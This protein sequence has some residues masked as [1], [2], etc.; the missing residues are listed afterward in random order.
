MGL[1][2]DPAIPLLG[3]FPKKL[4]ALS[5]MHPHTHCSAIYNSQVTETIW[6][7]IN[8]W[9]DRETA[10]CVCV[11]VCIH[12]IVCCFSRSGVSDS[13]W[14]HELWPTR[15][16][17]PWDSPGNNTGVGS[18]SLLQGSSQ[19][20]DQSWV[21]LTAGRFLIPSEPPYSVINK[22]KTL[23]LARARMD[24]KGIVLSEISQTKRDKYCM[25]S[26]T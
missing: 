22:N 24:L 23:P 12:T 16:F 25:I 15:R 11:C 20:R 26:H 1:P 5:R 9:M 8:G 7:S 21:S 4:K 2:C 6:V 18:H 13:L 10:L 3:I 19:T 17:C 14:P